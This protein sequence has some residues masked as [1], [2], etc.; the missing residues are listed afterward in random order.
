MSQSCDWLHIPMVVATDLNPGTSP[1]GSLLLAMS[2]AAVLF[3]LTSEEALW[4]IGHPSELSY[5]INMN[6]PSH[7]WQGG[8]C[9][10]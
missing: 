6:K 8:V 5:A 4:D 10:A 9:R 2:Q 1:S 3:G 7:V